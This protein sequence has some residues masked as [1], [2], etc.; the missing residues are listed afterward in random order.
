MLETEEQTQTSP[1]NLNL[2]LTQF[3]DIPAGEQAPDEADSVG[4]LAE[5]FRGDV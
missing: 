4:M 1:I 5:T 2:L 3:K